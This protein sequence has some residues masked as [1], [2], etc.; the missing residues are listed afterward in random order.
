MTATKKDY[1]QVFHRLPKNVIPVHYEISIKPDLFNLAFEGT[2]IITL[3]VFY[4]KKY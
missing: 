4:F 2:E 1:G 3:K